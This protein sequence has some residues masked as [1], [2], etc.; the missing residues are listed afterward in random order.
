MSLKISSRLIGDVLILDLSGRITLGDEVLLQDSVKGLLADGKKKILLNIADVN[1][2]DSA[3]LE[4]L[5]KAIIW[6]RRQGGILNLLSPTKRVRDILQMTGL[7]KLVDVFTDESRALESFGGPSL[8]C[9]CPVCG[10]AS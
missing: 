2:I 10:Y 3:G 7:I 5:G 6:P 8:H 9:C 1:Y 4:A